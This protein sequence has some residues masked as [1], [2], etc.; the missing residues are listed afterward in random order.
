MAYFFGFLLLCGGITAAVFG[1]DNMVDTNLAT[2]L[3]V[4][5][6]L[7]AIC[8]LGFSGILF[9]LGSMLQNNQKSESTIIDDED[10]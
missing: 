10:L 8:A 9:T 4:T 3:N 6:M 5:M 1:I 2:I 7:C